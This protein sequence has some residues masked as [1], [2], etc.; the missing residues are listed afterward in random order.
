MGKFACRVR[1]PF[2]PDLTGRKHPET[3]GDNS[4]NPIGGLSRAY[5]GSL[6]ITLISKSKPD[7]H[8][9]PIAVTVG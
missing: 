4:Q 7:N 2:L 1:R 3:I 6:A 5:C 9:T 8:V